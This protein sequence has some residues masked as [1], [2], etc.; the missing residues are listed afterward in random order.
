MLQRRPAPLRDFR[1]HLEIETPE[2]VVLDYEIAGLGS[3]V[4]AAFADWLILGFILLVVSLGLNSRRAV[5]PW[6]MAVTIL[7]M[8]GV[9]WGYFTCFEGLG[10]G[11]TPGK[12]WLGIRV[13]RDTGHGLTL[14]DAA[15]RNLP[16][17]VDLFCAL[18]VF[19]MAIHPRGKRL[20]D[21]VAGTVVVRDQPAQVA[22]IPAA[23]GQREDEMGAPELA[24]E[25]FRLLREF[26]SRAPALSPQVRAQLARGL[27]ARF[28]DR[29]PERTGDDYAFL[30]RLHREELA[31]RRGRFGARGTA[32][33]RRSGGGSVAERLGGR[34]S[35]R[36]DEYQSMAE[37]VTRHGLD[38]L[39]APELPDF[40]RRYREVAADLARARTYGADARVLVRLA[41][42]PARVL[43]RRERLVAAGHN[44]LYRQERRTWARIWAFLARECPG[45]IVESRRYVAPACLVFLLPA[46]GGFALLRDRPSLA[47]DLLPDVVL[48]RAEAGAARQ[49]VGE[50]YVGTEAK[51]RPLVASAIIANNIQVAFG[52]FAGGIAFGFGSLAYLAYN[53]LQIG[54]VSGHFANKGLL[55]YLWTFVIGHGVLELFAIWVAGAAGFLLGRALIA[56]GELTRRDALVLAGRQAMRLI[57]AV[58]VL[59]AVAGTIEGF[60]SSSDWPLPLRLG[61]SGAS[62]LFLLLYLGNGVASRR[63]AEAGGTQGDPGVTALAPLRP[64]VLPPSLTGTYPDRSIP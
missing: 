60:V 2:H 43:V 47:P 11:Q 58:I 51:A 32:G 24:D 20:G 5:S 55:G 29:Y 56:P 44:A 8:F 30:E 61:V 37:R 52:C 21:L 59:L 7:A 64:S 39:T 45:A 27:A 17:P 36:W 26:T 28:A 1:Q 50:G 57:G 3:R 13:I 42:L 16:L 9:V 62:V 41:R 35:A 31:R 25:E 10:R 12:R 34:K 22:A 14:P 63:R 48:E 4:L 33:P 49:A 15:A 19:F 40:A 23:D 38:A 6:L 18:G 54:A 53:G 46:A